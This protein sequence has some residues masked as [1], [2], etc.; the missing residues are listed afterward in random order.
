MG[1]LT[2]NGQT[3]LEQV[4][5]ARPTVGAGFPAGHIIQTTTPSV[6]TGSN[7]A[8]ANRT[9]LGSLDIYYHNPTKMTNTITKLYDNSFLL[10]NFNLCVNFIANSGAHSIVVFVDESIY[11]G[12]LHDVNR[13]TDAFPTALS[14]NVPFTNIN[15]GTYE[16]NVAICRGTDHD[17]NY[18]RNGR[19][20]P[21]EIDS[22]YCS[23]W[24][25]IQEIMGN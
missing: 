12:I 22:P 5:T 24:V 6:Y 25:Y 11:I 17:M 14:Y 20:Q 19:D 15:A 2:L 10:V 23:S 7:T 4:G 1:N 16:F 21:D 8:S 18:Q 13:N 9:R 3:V